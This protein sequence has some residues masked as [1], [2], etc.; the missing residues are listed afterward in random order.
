M[1]L[2]AKN[3]TS[4]DKSKGDYSTYWANSD[5][6]TD[7]YN[8]VFVVD[9]FIN[10]CITKN[11]TLSN[12]KELSERLC[13]MLGLETENQR[14]TLVCIKILS[15]SLFRPSY[16]TDITKRTTKADAGSN[17]QINHLSVKDRNWFHTR[18]LDKSYPWTR[19]GYTYD[20]Y[21][22]S[23][24]YVGVTEFIVKPFTPIMGKEY[25]TMD[26]LINKIKDRKREIEKD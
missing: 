19:M 7:W 10:R 21:D 1:G 13:K 12:S 24:N 5:S 15:D 2:L 6:T 20:W 23:D 8:W 22:M 25:I 16:N 17:S 3:K 14:D 9:D 18:Q 11:V 4:R 26:S